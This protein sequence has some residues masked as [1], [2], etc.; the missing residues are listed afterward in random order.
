MKTALR[1]LFWGGKMSKSK[2]ILRKNI[3]NIE[4]GLSVNTVKFKL[5]GEEVTE[6]IRWTNLSWK[7]VDRLYEGDLTEFFQVLARMKEL[8]ETTKKKDIDKIHSLGIPGLPDANLAIVW[9]LLAGGGLEL[10]YREAQEMTTALTND[11]DAL[12][13]CWKTMASGDIQEE[14]LEKIK[15]NKS[16]N[17]TK[18]KNLKK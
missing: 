7:I 16:S 14:D 9:G 3:E 15:T 4:K 17:N 5:F 1:I 18:K 13:D 10:T 12:S 6:H 11:K 8:G 2:E